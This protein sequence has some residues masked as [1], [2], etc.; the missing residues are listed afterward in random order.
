MD[1][2]I[3]ELE[4]GQ[5]S[6]NKNVNN[7][8][9]IDPSMFEFAK[10]DDFSKDKKFETKPIGYFQDALYRFCRNKAS[11]TAFVIICLLLLFAIFGPILGQ[12]NYSNTKDDTTYLRYTKLLPK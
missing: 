9:T 8:P 3:Q 10:R 6:M 4:W 2:S 1:S 12:S 5:D 11:V 7:I